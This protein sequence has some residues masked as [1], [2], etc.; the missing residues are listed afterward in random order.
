MAGNAARKKL[1]WI[2]AFCTVLTVLLHASGW[3]GIWLGLRDSIAR[4]GRKTAIHPQVVFLAIDQ[5]SLTLDRLSTA[6]VE[7]NAALQMMKNGWP[8]PRDIYPLILEKLAAAGARVIAFDLMFPTPRAGDEPF[9]N[10]LE[11]FR[12]KVVIGSNFSDAERERGGFRT[13]NAPAPT[14]IPSSSPLDDRVGFVNVW[15]D[16]DGIVRR[17][18]YSIT[19]EQASGLS[20]QNNTARYDSFASQI[21]QKAGYESAI[22]QG[23]E[24]LRFTKGFVPRSVYEIFVP[25]FWQSPQ[26]QHGESFR[27]KIVVIGPE[28]NWS[29]DL[30]PTPLGLLAGPEIHLT[31]INAVLQND[32]PR[33]LPLILEALLIASGGV[34]AWLLSAFVNR[35]MLRLMLLILAGAGFYG[36]G[37]LLWNLPHRLGIWPPVA[38]A[39]LALVSSG[40]IRLVW[41]QVQDRLE[42]ARMRRTLERYMS[43]N[44]VCEILD[45]PETYFETLGGVRKPVAIFFTD[46]RGFTTMT[47]EAD[48]S[49][50]VAQL[51]EYFTGMVRH[52]FE[53]DGTLD[54]FIGDAIMAVWG[55]IHTRG[56]AGDVARAVTTALQMKRSLAQLN[57]EWKNRGIRPLAMGIG[58][59]HGEAIVGNIGSP[60]KMELTVIGDCVNLASRLEGLSKHYGV[61]IVLG[62]NAAELVADQFHLQLLDNV[63]VAG[64]NIPLNIYTVHG[65]FNESLDAA[66]RVYLDQFAAGLELYR[67]GR[68][69]A[70]LDAFKSALIARPDDA[71]ANLY[72]SRCDNLR[73]SPPADWD[74][75]FVMTKK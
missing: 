16:P 28:G 31:A 41:E 36:L 20:T 67:K 71:V 4:H 12:D 74:G 23:T 62:E 14:L 53:N 44:L 66:T 18:Q 51:N 27:D 8:W 43:K 70:A 49:Q 1:T 75:V 61:E 10:A 63:R 7:S 46:L 40:L 47:E 24:L 73:L 60:E 29:K 19:A 30:I 39:M 32:F 33:Q 68:F 11:R 58:I 26:Y 57:A 15:P 48:S 72:I 34:A 25:A 37:L 50:V 9:H 13:Y 3:F 59:N 69:D 6:E 64:K 45:N 21:L 52:V 38:G 65:A 54:K 2:C 5:P 55:N 56:P 17:V 35:P 42:R 22:P